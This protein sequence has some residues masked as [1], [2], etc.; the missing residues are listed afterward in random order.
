MVHLLLGGFGS[1]IQDNHS[2]EP[3]LWT[4]SEPFALRIG[5]LVKWLEDK[6]DSIDVTVITDER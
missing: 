3:I 5:G 1:F 6:I 4:L 2:G